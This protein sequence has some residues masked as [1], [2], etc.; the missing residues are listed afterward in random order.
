MGNAHPFPPK[1]TSQLLTLAALADSL[2]SFLTFHLAAVSV[3]TEFSF[4]TFSSSTPE[5]ETKWEVMNAWLCHQPSSS[6][7]KSLNLFNCCHKTLIG[8][9]PGHNYWNCSQKVLCK[10]PAQHA[11]TKDSVNSFGCGCPGDRASFKDTLPQLQIIKEIPLMPVLLSLG[12]P[13][14]LH[15][16]EGTACL[17]QGRIQGRAWLISAAK[18]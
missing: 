3:I 4:K 2:L 14:R 11:W 9:F 1:S 13:R 16:T 8:A 10:S 15:I 18:V 7:S 12:L 6:Y 17:S 5:G